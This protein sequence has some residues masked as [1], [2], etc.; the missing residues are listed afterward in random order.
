MIEAKGSKSFDRAA[1][2]V[3]LALL[4]LAAIAVLDARSLTVTSA[5]GLGPEAMPYVIGAGLAVLGI[6]HFFVAFRSA[7]PERE[8]A[9]P[10][11]A[12][13]IALALAALIAVIAAGGGFMPAMAL[14]FAFTA[15]AFGR[16]AVLVDLAIGFVF[17]LVAYLL[18]TKLLSL[19]LPEGPIERLL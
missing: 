13:W 8:E 3:G 11:A 4:A 9:D 14:L 12:V 2:C 6:G 15:R 18:F 5:Y 7:L 1:A 17:A 16:K 10:W 19:S